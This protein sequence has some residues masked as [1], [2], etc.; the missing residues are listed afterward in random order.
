MTDEATI[1]QIL[2]YVDQLNRQAGDLART[3]ER[4][5]KEVGYVSLPC[6]GKRADWSVTANYDDP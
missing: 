4:Q 1:K 2:A 3:V 6:V 5:M